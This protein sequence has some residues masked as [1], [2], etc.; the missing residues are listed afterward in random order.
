MTS[1]V[2][3]R[4]EPGRRLRIAGATSRQSFAAILQ[5]VVWFSK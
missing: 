4:I 1:S 5:M 2:V 3:T